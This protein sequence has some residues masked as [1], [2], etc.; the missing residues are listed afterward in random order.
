[1]PIV[2]ILLLLIL[3]VLV[4]FPFVTAGGGLLVGVALL[5][6]EYWFLIV[7]GLATLIVVPVVQV[8]AESD[9][10]KIKHLDVQIRALENKRNTETKAWKLADIERS[11]KDLRRT[12]GHL[13]QKIR[14]KSQNADVSG[15]GDVDS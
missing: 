12:R 13:K 10:K 3:L 15:K 11:I 8:Y 5:V 14:R 4:G 2:I 6:Q 1:M 9:D 7:I